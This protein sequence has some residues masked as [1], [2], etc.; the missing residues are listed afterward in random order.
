ML[1]VLRGALRPAERHAPVQWAGAFARVGVP[2]SA[3]LRF[4]PAADATR[5]LD[6]PLRAGARPRERCVPCSE[7]SASEAQVQTDAACS[8]QRAATQGQAWARLGARALALAADSPGGPAAHGPA[9]PKPSQRR[10][11]ASAALLRAAASAAGQAG[12]R[13]GSRGAGSGQEGAGTAQG[14]PL[15]AARRGSWR[16]ACS[17]AAPA[18]HLE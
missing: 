6:W 16:A 3:A 15:H 1:A 8:V 17:D 11:E 2:A 5:V 12:V 18:P 10:V 4:I 9:A 7:S 14:L 13:R